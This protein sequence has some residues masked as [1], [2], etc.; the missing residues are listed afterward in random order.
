MERTQIK[1]SRGKRRMGQSPGETRHRL[2]VS[3]PW[4]HMETAMMGD[5]TCEVLQLRRLP[6]A[7]G[8]SV[9]LG[10]S[11]VGMEC[12]SEELSCSDSS[13]QVSRERGPVLGHTKT[14]LC[15]S[16][17]GLRAPPGGVKAALKTGLS[18]EGAG[19]KM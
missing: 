13:P 4:S 6:R 15:R 2:Q 10:V 3:L 5:Y 14:L 17:Q 9:L 16:V 8:P 11:Y 12:P 18:M 7:S 1:D 19:F